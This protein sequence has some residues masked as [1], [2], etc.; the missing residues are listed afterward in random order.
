MSAIAGFMADRGHNISGSDRAFDMN[1]AHPLKK[2]LE[3][4]GIM[5]VPQDG[6]G[7]N[8]SYDFAV[9]STAVEADRPE[10]LR[11]AKEGI[12]VKTRPDYLAEIVGSF[13][14]I[15][16]AGTSGKSTTSGLLA[17]LME[18]LGLSPNFI[19]GGRVKQF[20]TNTET[21]NYLSGDS[22][23]LIIEACESDGSIIK[24]HPE[25][26]IILNLDL[27]HHPVQVT[28]GMF[29]TLIKQTKGMVI[30]NAD[31]RN[32]S[33]IRGNDAITFSV[34]NRSTYKAE[35]IAY[36]QFSTEFILHGTKY[37]LPLPGAYNLY[38]AL[39]C[40]AFLIEI[41][42]PPDSIRTA[43][44]GFQGISRRFDIHLNNG[45]KLVI[46]DYAHNPH[47]ITALMETM[48]KMREGVCYIFQPHGFGPTRMMKKE[49]I[50]AFSMNL[51][52]T[53][54]LF[55]LP[56]FYAGGTASRDISSRDLAEALQAE[57]KSADAVESR[58][59]IIQGA[60]DYDCYVVMGARDDS[61][62]NLAASIAVQLK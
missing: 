11:A 5:I 12:T 25:H 13:R 23:S 27:D 60:G 46:D 10:A 14:A 61:L 26:T 17:F 45:N 18:R 31:D 16:V 62:M 6:S 15:A 24:Y 28:E 43:L 33:G 8:S 40:I 53:D 49:Y 58:E 41:G 34:H 35:E 36:H 37:S 38:N 39:A 55:L 30:L 20:M 47:K 56:I 29:R 7:I 3:A 22:D 32:L 57:G 48:Q 9:F 52:E 1:S 59:D 21:G 54:H 19:G 50:Q 4:K 44:K 2:T 51:R 42:I